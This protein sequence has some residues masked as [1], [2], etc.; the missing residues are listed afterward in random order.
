M[1]E[2][3]KTNACSGCHACYSV[4]PRQCITMSPDEEG[5]LYPKIDKD[6]CVG[7]GKC[8]AVCMHI[9]RIK[10]T[11]GGGYACINRDR[12]IRRKSSSGGVFSLLAEHILA[13]GGS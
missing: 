12:K 13:K 1:S 2:I 7:C 10:G 3:I 11:I 5:F 6:I 8:T 9:E 4:C